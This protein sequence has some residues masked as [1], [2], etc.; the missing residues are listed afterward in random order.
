MKNQPTSFAHSHEEI[1]EALNSIALES[2]GADE[3]QLVFLLERLDVLSSKLRICSK[4]VYKAYET[5]ICF[6]REQIMGKISE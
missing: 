2:T 5:H 4:C 3:E 1:Q 6:I